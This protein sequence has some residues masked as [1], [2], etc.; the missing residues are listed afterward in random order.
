MSLSVSIHQLL[1]AGGLRAVIPFSQLMMTS[2]SPKIFNFGIPIDRVT[3]KSAYNAINSALVLVHVSTPKAK[4]NEWDSF[5]Y[6]QKPTPPIPLAAAPSKKPYGETRTGLCP[7]DISFF[8][9]A[10]AG[11]Y[12]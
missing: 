1:R 8:T 4:S 3:C 2:E 9:L 10:A 6:R 12:N 11:L 5:R 7:I